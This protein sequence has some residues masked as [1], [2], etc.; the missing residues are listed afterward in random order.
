MSFTQ[1]LWDTVRKLA[2]LEARTE[3]VVRGVERVED[4]I[5]GL[6]E[7]LS[8]V[9]SQTLFLRENV[10]NEILADLKA[11]IAVLKITLSGH[12]L[13]GV[14]ETSRPSLESGEDGPS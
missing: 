11:E 5:D 12:V 13:G 4:K 2:A 7:R 10:R 3:D 14:A 9:E 1:E 8:R 6:I